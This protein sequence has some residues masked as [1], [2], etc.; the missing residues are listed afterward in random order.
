VSNPLWR[1]TS[2]P[3]L[4]QT[5][6]LWLFDLFSFLNHQHELH[7]YGCLSRLAGVQVK[8]IGLLGSQSSDPLVLWTNFHSYE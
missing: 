7:C 3:A 8:H 4:K 5:D 1:S 2:P 6:L